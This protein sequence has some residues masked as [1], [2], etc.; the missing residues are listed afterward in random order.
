MNQQDWWRV[1]NLLLEERQVRETQEQSKLNPR[2]DFGSYRLLLQGIDSKTAQI[3]EHND[4][5]PR[6]KVEAIARLLRVTNPASVLDVGCGVGYTTEALALNYSG[7]EVLGVDLSSDGIAFARQMH[8]KAFF[9]V[10]PVVP[11]GPSIGRFDLIFCFEFYPFTRN[12]DAEVQTSYI[13]YFINNLK[14]GGQLVIYQVWRNP[15]SL[16]AVYEKLIAAMPELRFDMHVIAHPKLLAVLP[17]PLARLAGALL[18]KLFGKEL[19]RKV[20]LISSCD[21]ANESRVENI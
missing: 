8:R 3:S 2:N 14:P 11:E 4:V 12:A 19:L 15:H 1:E 7:A 21:I 9:D 20:L 6:R 10:R 5:Q 17:S 13:R 18:G 16:S